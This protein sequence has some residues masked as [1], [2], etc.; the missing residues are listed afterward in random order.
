MLCAELEKIIGYEFRDKAL[1][2][3]A[4]THS[5]YANDVLGDTKLSNERLEYFGDALLDAIVGEI[6]FKRFPDKNEGFLTKLRAEIVC[7]KALGSA[8]LKLGINEF[9]LLGNGEEERGGRKRISIVADS[10]EAL[11]A[12]VYLD[13][14]ESAAIGNIRRLIETILGETVEQVCAGKIFSDSKTALQEK[15]QAKGI[16]DIRYEIIRESGPDHAK[17]FTAQVLVK[18]KAVGEGSGNSKKEA[19]SAAAS[20]ALENMEDQI[21]F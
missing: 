9:L 11:I 21:E 17:L 6:L 14:D 18:G 4:M 13:S 15:L 1:L 7:E 5:S 2:E 16:T 10:I 12:A 3:S 8:A 19:Q 20:A